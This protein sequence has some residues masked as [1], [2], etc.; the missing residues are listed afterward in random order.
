[1]VATIKIEIKNKRQFLHSTKKFCIEVV[2]YIVN[3]ILRRNKL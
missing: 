2:E 1:M 3:R